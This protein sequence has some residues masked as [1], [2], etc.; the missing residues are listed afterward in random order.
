MN[1]KPLY[2]YTLVP[3]PLYPLTLILTLT[4]LPPPEPYITQPFWFEAQCSAL[5]RLPPCACLSGSQRSCELTQNQEPCCSRLWINRIDRL[6]RGPEEEEPMRRRCRPPRRQHP[7]SRRLESPY[8]SS[9]H[10][11]RTVMRGVKKKLLSGYYGA[12]LMEGAC[13]VKGAVQ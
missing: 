8:P 12:S 10:P 2:P 7:Q 4:L 5:G 11:H 9:A 13:S 3:L 1:V 6:A